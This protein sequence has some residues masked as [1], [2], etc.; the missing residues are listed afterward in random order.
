MNEA[1][2][3]TAKWR[4]VRRPDWHHLPRRTMPCS[5]SSSSSSS[6]ASPLPTQAIFLLGGTP[7]HPPP[8]FFQLER[9]FACPACLSLALHRCVGPTTWPCCSMVPPRGSG[10]L[11]LLAAAHARRSG[12]GTKWSLGS[13]LPGPWRRRLHARYAA[14]HGTAAWLVRACISVLNK[15]SIN[16]MMRSNRL[17]QWLA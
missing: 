17:V 16:P 4:S 15:Y 14:V 2:T 13:A 9:R 8:L 3:G 6:M 10:P 12:H 5:S 1:A 11:A 7:A